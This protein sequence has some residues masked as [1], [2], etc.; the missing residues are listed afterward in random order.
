MKGS[1]LDLGSGREPMEHAA[2]D[3]TTVPEAP[4]RQIQPTKNTNDHKGHEG[5]GSSP[6][7]SCSLWSSVFFVASSPGRYAARAW[8]ASIWATQAVSRAPV[9]RC[10]E[11]VRAVRVRARAEHAGDDELRAREA[12]AEH[13]HERDR[14]ALALVT[15]L[16]A[17]AVARRARHRLRQPR[18]QRR[19][20]PAGRALLGVE[21]S[22]ARRTA[23]RRSSSVAQR[24][25]R[26]RARRASAAGAATA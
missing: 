13:G 15:G 6:A 2:R 20:V 5:L 22:P 25:G 1:G 8:S 11:L 14:A 10:E 3:S 19:R 18:R 4:R 26:A 21:A 17:E 24:R 16:A 23:D 9:A 12:L 7:P